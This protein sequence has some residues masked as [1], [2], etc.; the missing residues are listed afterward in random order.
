VT[1][2]L[3]GKTPLDAN[4][5]REVKT[6]VIQVETKGNE[7][8]FTHDEESEKVEG[9]AIADYKRVNQKKWS[10]RRDIDIVKP[11]D[12]I[13]FDEIGRLLQGSL[14]TLCTLQGQ[15]RCTA[16]ERYPVV[17]VLGMSG[18]VVG[19]PSRI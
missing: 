10:L 2:Y 16:V 8:C 7:V 3:E 19:G 6:L 5:W 9:S 12:F 15:S 14:N 17:S 13:H 1:L 4:G 18:L 11:Y